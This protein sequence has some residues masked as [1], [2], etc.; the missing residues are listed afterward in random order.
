MRTRHV[1][2]AVLISTAMFLIGCAGSNKYMKPAASGQ[3]GPAS[4]KLVKVKLE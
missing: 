2:I 1:A 4:F 3:D